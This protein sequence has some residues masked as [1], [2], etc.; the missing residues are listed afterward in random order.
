MPTTT[1]TTADPIRTGIIG[2]GLA[3][4]VFHAPFI[5]TDPAFRLDLIA[6]ASEERAADAREQHPEAEIVASPE[7]LL[8]RAPVT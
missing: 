2:F 3:G 1:P 5:A 8:A 6:T 4:R 7:E